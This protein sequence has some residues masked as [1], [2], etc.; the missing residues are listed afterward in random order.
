M[1]RGFLAASTAHAWAA[2]PV[3][4]RHELVV[5]L[6]QELS[7]AIRHDVALFGGHIRQQRVPGLPCP[8]LAVEVSQDV[9]APRLCATLGELS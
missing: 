1:R 7:E 2:I 9:V 3:H 5:P 4:H 6:L 8:P